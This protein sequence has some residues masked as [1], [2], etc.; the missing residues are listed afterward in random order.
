MNV[1]FVAAACLAVAALGAQGA[2]A[3]GNF[4]DKPLK[5]LVPVPPGGG[6]DYIARLIADKMGAQLGKPVLVDN[7]GGAS[8]GIA[9]QEVAR[10]APDGYTLMECYVATHGTNPAVS[11]LGYDP[12]KDFTPVGMIAAT[13]NVLVVGEQVKA[14]D[15]KE[16][17]ALA[18]SQPGRMSYGTTGVG[19]AT[20]LTMEYLKQQAGIDLIHVPYKGASPAMTDLIG[21]QVDAMFPGLTAAI[22]H[23][24]SGKLRP[25][26][27]S[28]EKRSP[29][30]PDVPTVSESG[31]PAFNALQWYGMC[32]PANTPRAVIERLNKALNTVLVSAEIR[33]KLA[34][35]AAEPMP[36]TPE[37]FGDFIKNDIAK[38]TRL[39][40]EAKLQIE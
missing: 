38:W 1:K 10:A 25:L 15:I 33:A 22:P 11:K 32:A 13:S 3:Q 2:W 9:A 24:K 18:K 35:H 5:L 23:I 12:V 34:E 36:M 8:G 6:A 37:Q 39:V 7:K 26:A 29:L 4:P 28:A 40:R 17:I 14:R 21:G 31:F 27:I 30:L 16:F 19:S 20:H